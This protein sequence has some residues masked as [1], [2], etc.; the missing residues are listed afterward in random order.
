MSA[1]ELFAGLG[2]T[3]PGG[4]VM[5]AEFVIEPVAALD[6]VPLTVN[7]A[8]PPT[9]RATVVLMLPDPEAAHVPLTAAQAHDPPVSDAG[10]R[11]VTVAPAMSDG[12]AFDTTTE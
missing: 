4:G 11:S 2:S 10:N 6:T 3:A 7:V 8:V 1:A 9:A 5:E 12:P